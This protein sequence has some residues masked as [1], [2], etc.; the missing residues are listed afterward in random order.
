MK[1]IYDMF[2]D[3]DVDL[4]EY[5]KED[6]ND[7]EKKKVKNKFRKSIKNNNSSKKNYKKYVSVASIAIISIALISQTKLGLYAQSTLEDI[8]E[9]IKVSLGV[10]NQITEYSTNVQQSVTK[11][12]LTV[13]I[14]DVILDGKELIIYMSREYDKKL[15]S[16]EHLNLV[17]ENLNI[18]GKRINGSIKGYHGRVDKNKEEF[19]LGYELP[20]EYKGDINVKLR[21]MDAA[22]TKTDDENY[23]KRIIGPW[24][25]KFK[26]N[27][28]KL[29]KDTKHIKLNKKIK[30]DTGSTMDIISYR[31]NILN[32]TINLSMTNHT[33][34]KSEVENGVIALK[35]RD[36]LGNKVEFT[37][38]LAD[39]RKE[40][41]LYEYRFNKDEYTFNR[42]AKYLKVTPYLSYLEKENNDYVTKYKKLGSEITIDLNK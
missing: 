39:V 34:M 5:E 36:N 12:N 35:G 23:F 7:L 25:F 4:N 8:A 27:G 19:V 26:V 20:K 33:H 17:S 18:N 41:T 37:Q 15:A 1:N 30:L 16:N 42:D 13:K 11:R 22:I 21:I 24:S 2:N 38:H 31:G 10:D 29:N 3:I 9:V 6:F 32:Q 40:K 28:D 14:N